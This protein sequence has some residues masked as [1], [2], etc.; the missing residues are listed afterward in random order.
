MDIEI[1]KLIQEIVR[2]S[3]LESSY[4][5]GAIES[6]TLLKERL[7]PNEQDNQDNEIPE[8]S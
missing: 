2:K 7:K 4:Y 1:D 5:K 6:L 8:P 3:E